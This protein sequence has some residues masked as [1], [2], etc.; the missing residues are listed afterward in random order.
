MKF[1]IS[2]EWSV[3]VEEKGTKATFKGKINLKIQ[4]FILYF[5][6]KS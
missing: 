5:V 2:F 1:N 4:I 6:T 3:Q